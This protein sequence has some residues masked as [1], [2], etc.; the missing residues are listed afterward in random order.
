MSAKKSTSFLQVV[1]PVSALPAQSV[2][3]CDPRNDR[4]IQMQRLI[5][6]YIADQRLPISIRLLLDIML[7]GGCRV[8]EVIQPGGFM[9]LPTG[10]VKI[11]QSKTKSTHIFNLTHLTSVIDKYKGGNCILCSGYSRFQIYRLFKKMGIEST[12]DGL[13]KSS[14]CH[15][16]RHLVGAL[17]YTTDHNLQDVAKVLNHANQKNS[18]YYVKKT[19]SRSASK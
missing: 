6:G 19:K 7:S 12:F 14:V 13:S 16:P 1:K 10:A 15:L 9:V 18:L 4:L 5:T 11:Y 8:S 2:I 17:T 3:P